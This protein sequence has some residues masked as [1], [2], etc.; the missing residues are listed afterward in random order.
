MDA[1]N[2]IETFLADHPGRFYCNRCLSDELLV[3]SAS[4]ANQTTRFL[5]SIPP[6]R[7]GKMICARCRTDR[8]CL[9]YGQEPALP[10]N[11]DADLHA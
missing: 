5:R 11:V 3:F 2:L 4:R 9:A 10:D 7:H 8:Q 6:Y 1:D